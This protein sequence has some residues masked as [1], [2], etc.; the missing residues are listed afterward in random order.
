ML[1][2][3]GC[4]RSVGGADLHAGSLNTASR[5]RRYGS[6]SP[7]ST[8]GRF[9]GRLYIPY[10]CHPWSARPGS[11]A[12]FASWGTHGQAGERSY[13]GQEDSGAGRQKRSEGQCQ[14]SGEGGAGQQ[15]GPGDQGGEE[16]RGQA[17][18]QGG[19]EGHAGGSGEEGYA[20]GPGQDG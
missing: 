20:G 8:C 5:L 9:V 13:G 10:S 11:R 6:K 12:H 2:S 19:E 3:S 17:G 16:G 18:Q 15:V 7:I 4:A 14:G 1:P